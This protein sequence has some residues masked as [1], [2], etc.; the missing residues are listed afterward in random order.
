MNYFNM[1]EI[2]LNNNF[3]LIMNSGYLKEAQKNSCLYFC[4]PNDSIPKSDYEPAHLAFKT[5]Q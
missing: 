4:H 5:R 1:S 2:V 3:M